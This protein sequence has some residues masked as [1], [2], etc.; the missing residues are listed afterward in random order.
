MKL[1]QFVTLLL[2]SLVVAVFWG[3]WLGLSR[4]LADLSPA[5]FLEV[6]RTMIG[7]L[8]GAMRILMPSTLLAT[9]ALVVVLARRHETFATTFG[10]LA[11]VLLVAAMAV[12]L[13]VNVPIDLQIR[14]WTTETL[15]PAWEATRDRWEFYHVTRTAVSLAGLACLFG[16]VLATR[17][18]VSDAR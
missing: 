18:P 8:G 16:S 5:T 10:A 11:L 7:N 1:A 2:Y 3:T 17:R 6:G 14:S 12:T 13:L 4:S 9:T 15:P